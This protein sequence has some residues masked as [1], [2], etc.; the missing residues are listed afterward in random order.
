MVTV[1]TVVTV[2]TM[3]GMISVMV[4]V[5]DM[6]VLVMALRIGDRPNDEN[7]GTRGRTGGNKGK[8]MPARRF[9]RRSHSEIVRGLNCVDRT[10]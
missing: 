10:Q 4:I 3:S 5:N 6:T 1:V 7:F 8:G 2:V 9:K